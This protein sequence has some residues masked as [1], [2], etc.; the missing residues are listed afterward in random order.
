MSGL[1]S[2]NMMNEEAIS[3]IIHTF[4]SI[5]AF[6]HFVARVPKIVDNSFGIIAGANIRH[7]LNIEYLL[8][9]STK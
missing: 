5:G 8:I 2:S 4:G 9:H 3:K 1:M 6:K 7:T